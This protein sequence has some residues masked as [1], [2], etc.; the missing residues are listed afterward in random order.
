MLSFFLDTWAPRT[1]TRYR[2]PPPDRCLFLSLPWSRQRK[3]GW[4]HPR[5]KHIF[6]AY[7]SHFGR[8]STIDHSASVPNWCKGNRYVFFILSSTI[9]TYA[10]ADCLSMKSGMSLNLLSLVN[11]GRK[12][13]SLLLCWYLLHQIWGSSVGACKCRS[14]PLKILGGC[15]PHRLKWHFSASNVYN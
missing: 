4:L 11:W 10:Q 15:L 2:C 3:R 5:N 7:S 12:C 14:L 6:P 9:V 13:N 1:P 8:R